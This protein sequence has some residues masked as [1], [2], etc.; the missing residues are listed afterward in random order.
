MARTPSQGEAVS[1]VELALKERAPD[2]HQRLQ[3]AGDL[4]AFVDLYARAMIERIDEL[5]DPGPVLRDGQA[6][7]LE[8]ARRIAEIRT[9]AVELVV[10]E[11]LSTES[12]RAVDPVQWSE[13]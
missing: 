2:V 5:D 10:A 3:V 8:R 6:P 12:L 9:R 1:M 13:R 7:L 4:A 11:M